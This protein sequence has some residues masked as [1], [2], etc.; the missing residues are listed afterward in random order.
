MKR[1]LE[2][3][4]NWELWPFWMRY[5]NITPMWLW[6]CLKARSPWFFTASNPTISFGGFE[7]ES[8]SEMYEQLP[9]GSFP[10]TVYIRPGI[11]FEEV[12]DAVEKNGFTYPFIVKPD[13]GMSGILFRKIKNEQQLRDYHQKMPADYMIQALVELPV[14]YSVFYYRHP[15]KTKGVITGFLQKEPLHIIGDGKS[16]VKDLIDLH[17]KAKHRIQ[18]LYGWHEERLV[19][20]LPAAEK[21]YLTHAANLN[22]GASFINLHEEIDEDLH[23]VFD[24]LN[25]YSKTFYYGRYDLKATSVADLK[26]G[27]NFQVLEYNG[28]GAEPNH[29]Y[30]SGYSLRE[31]HNEILKHWKVLYEISVFNHQQGIDYW[32]FKK[33]WHYLQAAKKH[34]ARLKETDA[35][36]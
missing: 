8:K 25:H 35:T 9:P 34:F 22:R 14:E 10:K 23:R 28:S 27:K 2:K 16:T 36:T 31:A 4:T 11:A 29:V 24:A 6:Y 30:N 1:I 33:G 18:E 21:Y 17:P 32:P 13:V 19:D 15:A 20:I 12:K 5:I 3:W 7:G 26:Q